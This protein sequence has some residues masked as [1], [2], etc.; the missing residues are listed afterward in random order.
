VA[1]AE[2]SPLELFKST[3]KEINIPV[4][5][6]KPALREF[7]WRSNIGWQSPGDTNGAVFFWAQR[8]VFGIGYVLK[9]SLPISWAFI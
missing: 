8:Y 7:L 5:I 4:A 6:K 1:T 2:I 3:P 9:E